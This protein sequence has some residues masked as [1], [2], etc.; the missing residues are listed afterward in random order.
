MSSASSDSFTSFSTWIPF[1]YFSCLTAMTNTFNIIFNKIGNSGHSCPTTD[2]RKM[3][4]GFH[5]WVWC[6]LYNCHMAFM[7]FSGGIVV[8]DPNLSLLCFGSLLCCG[9]DS[10]TWI[11][12]YAMIAAK[13]ILKIYG[14]HYIEKSS[15]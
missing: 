5:S 13:K 12:L 3:V 2:C 4:S 6:W 8:M 7:E 14:L 9:F 15:L 11:L 10:L 1:I